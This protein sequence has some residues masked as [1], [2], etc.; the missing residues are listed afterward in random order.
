ML[1][2]PRNYPHPCPSGS[3]VRT[4]LF[5]QHSLLHCLWGFQTVHLTFVKGLFIPPSFTPAGAAS[6]LLR[7]C[8]ETQGFSRNRADT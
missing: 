4:A 2:G 8:R 7:G 5:R 1:P 6:R 3:G